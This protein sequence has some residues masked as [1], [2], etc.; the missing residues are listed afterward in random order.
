MNGI[1]VADLV[2]YL[3]LLPM[4]V[5]TCFK[6]GQAGFL[7]WYFFI[8]FCGARIAG[9]AL[10]VHDNQSLAASILQSVGFTPIILG[11]DGMVHEAYVLLV[12]HF[13]IRRN[14]E[15]K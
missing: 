8:I 1:F 10:G 7:P 3:L 9:G 6:H 13:A 12:F 11:A 5:Y 2:V 4:A 14:I 15:P